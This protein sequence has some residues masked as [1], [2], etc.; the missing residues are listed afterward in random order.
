ME[1]KTKV[2][3]KNI[4]QKL[5]EVIEKNISQYLE[6]FPSVPPVDIG[7]F[8]AK[9]KITLAAYAEDGSKVWEK[10]VSQKKKKL[11]GSWVAFYQKSLNWIS[12]QNLSGETL[13]VFLAL[14]SRLDFENYIPLNQTELSKEMGIARPNISRAI[15]KLV[16]LGILTEGPRAGLNKMYMLNPY[17]GIKGRQK[18]EKVTEFKVMKAENDKK[19][20]EKKAAKSASCGFT[21]IGLMYS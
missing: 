12:K 5:K 6:S 4:S 7:N 20:R 2:A 13:N 3:K 21:Q 9:L 16:E 11:G 8:D 19:K 18:K 10:D 15:R 17:V 1:E 14:V